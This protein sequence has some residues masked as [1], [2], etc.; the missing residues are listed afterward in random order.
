MSTARAA[1]DMAGIHLKSM[2]RLHWGENQTST[3]EHSRNLETSMA[4]TRA[5]MALLPNTD[6]ALSQ[7]LVPHVITLT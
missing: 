6:T 7:G 5:A 2:E 1:L 4:E 3:I